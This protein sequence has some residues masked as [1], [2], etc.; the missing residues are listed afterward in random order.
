MGFLTRAENKIEDAVEGT[1]DKFVGAPISPIQIAKKCE[2]QMKRNKMVGAGKQ[3]APTLYTIMVNMDD[4]RRLFGYYPTLA[5]ETE[6]Y[7]DARAHDAGF[8]L[9][10]KPLVRFIADPAL[11]RGKFDVIAEC[12]AAPIVERLREEEMTRYGISTRRPKRAAQA[13]APQPAPVYNDDEYDDYQ[14]EYD[15]YGFDDNNDP[16]APSND[17]IFDEVEVE[18]ESE[19]ESASARTRV[20]LPP[21]EPLRATLLETSTGH[22]FTLSAVN[23]RVGRET[24]NDI[25]VADMGASRYHAEIKRTEKGWELVDSNSTNGTLVNGR[26]ISSRILRNGDVITIGTTKYEFT[27]A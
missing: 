23:V 20:V 1:A 21:A 19:D 27:Q 9:D 8:A 11:K 2:K 16:F 12:V 26:E 24:D 3:I 15:D 5:G 6:T 22:A 18:G 7:I 25:V 4:D 17:F 10:G 13:Y 14:D